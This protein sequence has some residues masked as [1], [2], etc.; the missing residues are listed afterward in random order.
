MPII[1]RWYD[2]EK[3]MLYAVHEGKWTLGEY[4]ENVAL[5][6]TMREEV[7][8]PIVIIISFANSDSLPPNMLSSGRQAERLANDQI[9]AS[10][11]YGLDM[12]H[13][14][15]GKMFMKLFPKIGSRTVF[16]NTLEEAVEQA[17]D[18][19]KHLTE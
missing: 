18:K 12:Y 13:Q 15:I 8:H 4:Y 10:V 16:V 14:I 9:L 19:L 2:D 17:Q 6:Q 3:M 5:M 11:V 1:T 7:T